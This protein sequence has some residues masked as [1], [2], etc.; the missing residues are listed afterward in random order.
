MEVGISCWWYFYLSTIF[1]AKCIP[2]WIGIT[3]GRYCI[4]YLYKF[5]QP[6]RANRNVTLTGVLPKISICQLLYEKSF[7]FSSN[8]NIL[9]Q[10]YIYIFQYALIDH[11]HL[12]FRPS[13]PG[14]LACDEG[15]YLAIPSLSDSPFLCD[16]CWII[17]ISVFC[18]KYQEINRNLVEEE[19]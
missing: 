14:F 7:T 16:C 18:R 15:F 10:I 1:Q 11:K 2:I 17:Y 3:F 4:L 19:M 6:K 12:F 5:S 9:K 8:W 13:L